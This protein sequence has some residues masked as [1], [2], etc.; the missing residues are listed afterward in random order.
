[1]CGLGQELV[2]EPSALS[3]APR[4][5]VEHGQPQPLPQPLEGRAGR[6]CP[7][8]PSARN[9]SVL[10]FGPAFLLRALQVWRTPWPPLQLPPG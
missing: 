6:P 3:G 8:I 10:W 7:A 5:A 9:K 2:Q 4:K 1:M